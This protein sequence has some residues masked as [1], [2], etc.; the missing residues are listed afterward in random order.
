[1]KR[2]IQMPPEVTQVFGEA[3][4]KFVDFLVD[5]FLDQKDEVMQMSALSFERTL[6]REIGSIRVE[7]AELRTET[8]TSIAQ[9]RT[10]MAELRADTQTSIAELRADMH[11]QISG[12]QKTISD[13]H[14]QISNQTKWILAMMLA[15]ITLY[16]VINQLVQRFL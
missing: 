11:E 15:A 6:S 8:Q 7:M 2:M 14:K 3:A 5:V 10:E 9:L 12:V 16:P 13:V 1:M 4:P